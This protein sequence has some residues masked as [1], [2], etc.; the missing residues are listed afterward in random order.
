MMIEGAQPGRAPQVRE[1]RE[2]HSTAEDILRWLQEA[3]Q[4]LG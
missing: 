4:E 1:E 3:E 2:A